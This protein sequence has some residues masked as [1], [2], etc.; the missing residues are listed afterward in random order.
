MRTDDTK[1]ADITESDADELAALIDRLMSSGTQHID[2]NVGEMTRVR[3]L[4]STECGRTGPC[5]VPNFDFAEED[6]KAD[7]Q[8]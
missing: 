7:E 5:A 2:L 4:N 8:D 3:T 6:E 1:P